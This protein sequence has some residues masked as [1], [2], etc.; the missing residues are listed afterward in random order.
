MEEV[1]LKFTDALRS[2][3]MEARDKY[4][5]AIARAEHAKNDQLPTQSPEYERLTFDFVQ[6]ATGGPLPIMLGK[7]RPYI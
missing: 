4:R 2:H 1:R 6:Q 5:N 7:W 3:I